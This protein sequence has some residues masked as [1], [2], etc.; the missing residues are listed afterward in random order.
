MVFLKNNILVKEL[1]ADFV[2][3][4]LLEKYDDSSPVMYGIIVDVSEEV[5]NKL[6]IYG[7]IENT[8]LM[9]KRVAKVPVL[10]GY[11]V[12]Y[13]DVIALMSIEEFNKLKGGLL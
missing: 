4:G 2:I 10:G 9:F 13:D 3:D 12:N 6:T 5:R 7:E 8:I 1:Q 11:L